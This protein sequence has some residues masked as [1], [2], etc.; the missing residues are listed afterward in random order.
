MDKGW[1]RAPRSTNEYNE[2]VKRFIEFAFSKSAKYNRIL[3]PCKTCQNAYWLVK[4]EVRGHL[5]SSGFMPG[6]TSWIHHGE[7]MSSSKPGVA[8]S[9]QYEY[10]SASGDE[11]D[12]ML[13]DGFGM[14]DTQALGEDKGLHEDLDVDAEAYYKLVNDNSQELYPGCKKFSKL[15][16]LVRLLNIKNLWGVS[17]D[18]FDELLSL[19]KEALPGGEALPK[20][21]H[22]AKK[23]VKA[24]GVAYECINACKNDYILY[25]KEYA[26]ATSCP[27]CGASRWKIEKTGVDGRRVHRVPQKVVRHFPLKKRLQRLFMSSKTAALMRWHSEDRTKDGLLRHPATR[28]L[29]NTLMQ[30][31]KISVQKFGMSDSVW[32]QMVSTPLE[33]GIFHIAYGL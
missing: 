2:G 25:R 23:F 4:E 19:I 7:S 17:N 11:M 28:L 8:S 33:I 20:N 5:V 30:C 15:Q 12:R 32:Q 29:G 9:P 18:C 16:F 6:Y 31:T 21:F 24:I 3:C 22:D 26:N 14:Y 10:G 1:M 13:M 27:V